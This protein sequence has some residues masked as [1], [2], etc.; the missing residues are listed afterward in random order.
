MRFVV[1]TVDLQLTFWGVDRAVHCA[2]VPRYDNDVMNDE[3]CFSSPYS[4]DSTM[5]DLLSQPVSRSTLLVF[6]CK[7]FV[8]GKLHLNPSIFVGEF[9]LK[10]LMFDCPI[11][12]S[13]SDMV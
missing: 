4:D 12:S 2:A 3:Q 11:F 5:D 7:L 8:S 6:V 13:K 9:L 1:D 10:L